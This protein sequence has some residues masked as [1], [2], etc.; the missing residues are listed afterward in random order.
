MRN[1][2]FLAASGNSLKRIDSFTI[3]I[4]VFSFDSHIF[5]NNLS[6]ILNLVNSYFGKI[7]LRT[8]GNLFSKHIRYTKLIRNKG[9]FL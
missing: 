1:R 2:Y 8:T 5:L 3:L 6:R 7:Q 9:V 4:T